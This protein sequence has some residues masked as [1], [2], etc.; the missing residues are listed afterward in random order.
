MKRKNMVL[1]TVAFAIC[2]ILNTG[3]FC[4]AQQTPADAVISSKE[5]TLTRTVM[6]SGL[7]IRGT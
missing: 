2:V 5:P 7:Q 1:F 6:L 4:D 3:I